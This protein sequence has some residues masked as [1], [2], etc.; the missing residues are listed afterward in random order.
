[1]NKMTLNT[2]SVD[3]VKAA[4]WLLFL[5]ALVIRLL[6]LA[7]LQHTFELLPYFMGDALYY[8][9]FAYKIATGKMAEYRHEVVYSPV[10]MTYL[11]AIYK[12]F[13]HH[14]I[15]SRL[16]NVLMESA[17]CV[18]IYWT[19]RTVWNHRAGLIAGIIAVFYGAYIF[20]SAELLKPSMG[21]FLMALCML[22]L[23]RNARHPRLWQWLLAGALLSTAAFARKNLAIV[24][25]VIPV[26]IFTTFSKKHLMKSLIYILIF[27]GAMIVTHKSWMT[28]YRM[29]NPNQ[30]AAFSESGIH[31]YIGTN[32]MAHGTY[33]RIPGIQPS[34][35]GHTV[36]AKKVAQA[37][38]RRPMSYAEADRYWLQKGIAFIFAE[39][40]KWLWLEAKK[41]FLML[42]DYEVPNDENYDYTR[43]LSWVLALPFLS[44]GLI[45]PL[46]FMGIFLERNNRDPA[47]RLLIYYLAAYMVSLLLTFVTM[48]YR[49]PLHLPLILF[50]G[51]TLSRLPDLWREK[52]WGEL[53]KSGLVFL[54]LFII[55]NANTFMPVVDYDHT[56]ELRMQRARELM[57]QK[58]APF[59]LTAEGPVPAPLV[60][61]SGRM[62]SPPP[63][64]T[65]LEPP[66]AESLRERLERIRQS[67]IRNLQQAHETS[68]AAGG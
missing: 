1:M 24:A 57:Q 44:F 4:P 17:V 54:I 21:N 3:W 32:E 23:I 31:F 34:A 42:N 67:Q 30:E 55:G 59:M 6:H 48:A 16:G 68:Q 60:P 47:V 15:L 56:T 36:D 58:K 26:W 11:A 38:T 65:P 35:I 29:I 8:D 37:E 22:L 27:A 53:K 18:F 50:A 25:V 61:G 49:Y 46:G 51:L 40:L 41:L 64:A 28:W 13:G 39:P 62:Q 52:Q 12:L 45:A 20:Y 5:A 10:F 66:P 2:P 63:A 19:A 14:T 43:K 33:T 7:A 9:V